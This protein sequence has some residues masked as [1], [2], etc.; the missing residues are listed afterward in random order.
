[1]RTTSF[2]PEQ[3]MI[4]IFRRLVCATCL[5]GA[6]TPGGALSQNLDWRSTIES[7]WAASS[8]EGGLQKSEFV[9]RTELEGGL[10]DWGSFTIIGQLRADPVDELEPGRA[11][12]SND[13]R[14]PL[15]RRGFIGDG[16]DVE[17]REAYL[18]IYAGR[19]FWRIGKQQVV[20]GQADGLRVLDAVNPLQF[21]EFILG[22][23]EDRRIPLWMINYER[24]VGDAVLQLLWV[25]DHTYDDLPGEGAFAV[26]STRSAPSIP[27]GM[28]GGL[29]LEQTDR[30]DRFIVDDD[31]GA[32]LSGFTSGWDWSLNYLY[33]YSDERVLHREI[34][35]SETLTVRPG[36]ERT[37]LIGGSGS[38]AFGKLTL[39]LEAGWFSD[40]FLIVDDPVDRDGVAA[41][42]ELRYVIGADYQL[43]GDTLL[44]AQVFQSHLLDRPG[45]ARRDKGE[46]SFTLLARRAFRNN[47]IEAEG[48]L[49]GSADNGDGV[50]QL[51]LDYELSDS[52]SVGAGADLFFGDADGLYGQFDS[53][54]RI[55][56]SFSYDF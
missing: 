10:G 17:L 41:S 5:T 18:D 53:A 23:F 33:T 21:R 35:A 6:F 51:S 29:T 14:G 39:R 26:T 37:H 32:R 36:Y 31:Y 28:S 27:E 22:D 13:V 42:Q 48:L 24:P 52:V 8:S 19:G 34:T 15:N 9:F 11:D 7:E 3:R 46:T 16:V 30:P 4:R 38:N 47:T 55:T 45:A 12:A 44:S 49:I 25:P 40:R 1:M 20:W 2:L 54:D 50:L 43:D 56:L